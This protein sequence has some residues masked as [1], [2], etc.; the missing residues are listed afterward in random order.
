MFNA[1]VHF[2]KS[3][4]RYLHTPVL[5][6]RYHGQARDQLLRDV[7]MYLHHHLRRNL[8]AY[9]SANSCTSDLV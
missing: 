3:Q 7:N 5:S 6:N 8:K 1:P 4:F 9:P 2:A